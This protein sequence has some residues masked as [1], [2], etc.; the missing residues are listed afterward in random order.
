VCT[1]PLIRDP[2]AER[3]SVSVWI[4]PGVNPGIPIPSLLPLSPHGGKRGAGGGVVAGFRAACAVGHNIWRA[5]QAAD[6]PFSKCRGTF[7][8]E[9][10]ADSTMPG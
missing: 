8:R 4:A 6:S 7:W 2:A 9:P 10:V 3:R 1:F 5:I